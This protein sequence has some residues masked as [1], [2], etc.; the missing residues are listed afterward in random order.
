MSKCILDDILIGGSCFSECKYNLEIVMERL[1]YYNVKVNYEKCEFLV[2]KVEYLGHVICEEGLKP[3]PSKVEAIIKAPVPQNKA[4]LQSYSEMLNF[5]G[6][7]IPNLSDELSIVYKLLRT[8]VK[9][10]CNR[11]FKKSKDLLCSNQLLAFYDPSKP[12]IA[13]CVLVLMA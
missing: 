10:E 9:F 6:K 8:D 12:I 4:Q 1:L 2:E 11:L 5:Y 13:S 3:N 7:F